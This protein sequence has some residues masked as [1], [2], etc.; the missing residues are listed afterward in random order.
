MYKDILQKNEKQVNKQILRINLGLLIL[1]F[2]VF[3]FVTKIPPLKAF[4]M[5]GIGVLAHI[6][7]YY[8][9][10]FGLFKQVTKYMY[11][12]LLTM[13]I[14]VFSIVMGEDNGGMFYGYFLL[15][16]LSGFYY[17]RMLLAVVGG[18]VL[19]QNALIY[20]L[21]P[22]TIMYRFDNV[23]GFLG[24]G[25]VFIAGLVATWV[26]VQR[27]EK[28]VVEAY[29][30]ETKATGM[31]EAVEEIFTNVQTISGQLNDSAHLLD[32]SAGEVGTSSEET[33]LSLD[34]MSSAIE[35]QARNTTDVQKH[36]DEINRSVHKLFQTAQKTG[37]LSRDTLVSS[38]R[39]AQ[40]LNEIEK[41]MEKMGETFDTTVTT[42][43]DLG[44]RSEEI[45]Q[46]VELIRSITSQ[47]NLLALNAAIEAARAGEHGL[48]FGVV[49]QEIRGL[50]DQSVQATEQIAHII[51][52]IQ[53]KIVEVTTSINQ[54]EE[55]LHEGIDQV[56][57]V[58][59]DY[60]GIL[61]LF[62]EA[63]TQIQEMV[64]ELEMVAQRNDRMMESIRNL[65][66]RSEENAASVEEISASME[67]QSA[68]TQT[69]VQISANLKSVVNDLYQLTQK[70]H[71][72]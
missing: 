28:L 35:E 34:H 41:S 60:Q 40:A 54:S 49:A 2:L 46:I 68:M 5:T 25:F 62:Q 12:L 1:A 23:S 7:I 56:R 61:Q 36:V 71:F 52:F 37:T 45:G 33:S 17:H 29:V 53:K 9:D 31:V 32:G 21:S 39:G 4:V 67:E 44:Q 22:Q 72:E 3:A 13:I 59:V 18:C 70:V 47:T 26:L 55:D 38:E 27:M 58:A 6:G 19:L 57:N 30:N 69:L 24:F 64:S 48:G 16:V 63:N 11:L 42:I 65:A 50:A 51:D 10:R 20:L 15:L 66:R 14:G 43:G 8:G